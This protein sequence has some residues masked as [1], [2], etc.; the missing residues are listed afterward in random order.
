[1]SPIYLRSPG[2]QPCLYSQPPHLFLGVSFLS[3]LPIIC[4]S[5]D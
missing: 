3:S 1:M 4:N 5:M 2:T